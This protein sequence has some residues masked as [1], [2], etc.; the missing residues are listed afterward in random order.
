MQAGWIFG[1]ITSA[2]KID[3]TPREEVGSKHASIVTRK[4]DGKE[5]AKDL[6]G[7]KANIEVTK[8]KVDSKSNKILDDAEKN[9]KVGLFCVVLRYFDIINQVKHEKKVWEN[10]TD[11]T[12][13]KNKLKETDER[14]RMK[15]EDANAKRRTELM[16]RY[17][18]KAQRGEV[19]RL[20]RNKIDQNNMVR[21]TNTKINFLFVSIRFLTLSFKSVDRFSTKVSKNYT[22][23]GVCSCDSALLQRSNWSKGSITMEKRTRRYIS[24][25]CPLQCISSH[26]HSDLERV[27][28]SK[29]SCYIAKEHGC[30][31]I[32]TSRG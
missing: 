32:R 4:E 27:L 20:L 13:N 9:I 29:G 26:Y 12:G 8:K 6:I 10:N 14:N 21:M 16:S 2:Q 18:E 22:E 25:I 1:E 11:I 31:Y 3:S 19:K 7:C 24:A 23:R 17:F 28:G 15:E 30:I 5:N